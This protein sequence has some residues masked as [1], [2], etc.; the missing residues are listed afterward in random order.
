MNTPDPVTGEPDLTDPIW[1]D[2]AWVASALPSGTL[3]RHHLQTQDFD[4]LPEAV[5]TEA[6]Q[7]VE[8]Q[9]GT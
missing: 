2:A 7:I 6:T 5:Q 1:L 3:T 8:A 4:Q 9:T